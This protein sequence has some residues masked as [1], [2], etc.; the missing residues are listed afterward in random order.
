MIQVLTIRIKYNRDKNTF[1]WYKC[2]SMSKHKLCLHEQ[3]G[4]TSLRACLHRATW[5][6]FQFKFYSQTNCWHKQ[7]VLFQ[8]LCC[9]PLKHSQAF[10][11]KLKMLILT[12]YRYFSNILKMQEAKNC[13][14]KLQRFL[15]SLLKLHK[16]LGS[17]TLN[18][19]GQFKRLTTNPRENEED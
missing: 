15:P 4:L 11:F 12:S 13:E 5:S 14:K 16:Y 3:K 19:T 17:H 9:F 8:L 2:T 10:K 1:L 7:K 6:E 18:E